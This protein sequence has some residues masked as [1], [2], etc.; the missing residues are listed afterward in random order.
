MA[1]TAVMAVVSCRD[2]DASLP[3]YEKLF[4]AAPDRR[5]M[6]GLAEWYLT[7]AGAVQ[8]VTDP[9]RAGSAMLT[10]NVDDLEDFLAELVGPEHVEEAITDATT[11]RLASLADPDGNIVTIAEPF[12]DVEQDVERVAG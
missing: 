11:A 3:W 12:A 1:I 5:P 6:D 8:L 9:E 2:L 4:G 10:L 7:G